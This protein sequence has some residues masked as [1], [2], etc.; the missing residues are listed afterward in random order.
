MYNLA[1]SAVLVAVGLGGAG[2]AF[3][4]STQPATAPARTQPTTSE[5]KI[6]FRS[7]TQPPFD[8][9]D[10]TELSD[11][12]VEMSE[13][14]RQK[15]LSIRDGHPPGEH[16]AIK[17][18]LRKTNEMD[19]LTA[20]QLKQLDS[21]SYINMLRFPNRY[22]GQMVRLKVVPY[23]VH[24]LK[25][26]R[27][28]YPWN[29]N[30]PEKPL[31][32]VDALVYAEDAD[33]NPDIEK[34]KDMPILLFSPDDPRDV[35]GPAEYDEAANEYLYG[36]K[37]SPEIVNVAAI[38][39]KVS[40]SGTRAEDYVFFPIVVANQL[41]PIGAA[42]PGREGMS[43][44]WIVVLVLFGIGAMLF[45]FRRISK[46]SRQSRAQEEFAWKQRL[47]EA[48]AEVR[49]IKAREAGL[50]PEELEELE[51]KLDGNVDES[52]RQAAEEFRRK[53]SAHDE[54]SSY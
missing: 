50:T 33:G 7:P 11:A 28:G 52:L 23:V 45:L 14:D 21:P 1:L 22:R 54:D 24:V 2:R 47:E 30:A 16:E 12:A 19:P 32:R 17:M 42:D 15:L 29:L 18:L 46:G 35:L 9:L 13:S 44:T 39:Y 10:E 38:F 31:Y 6:I 40:G 43:K 53:K 5:A 4:Q 25:P 36:K 20:E 34:M 37:Q 26:G 8:P 49:R 51:S 41:E 48:R 3:G 27:D